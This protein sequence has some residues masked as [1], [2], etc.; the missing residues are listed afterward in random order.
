VVRLRWRATVR[1]RVDRGDVCMSAPGFRPLVCTGEGSRTWLI[2][3]DADRIAVWDGGMRDNH[4]TCGIYGDLRAAV[5]ALDD[6][7]EANAASI[8]TPCATGEEC[9]DAE[10]EG[11]PPLAMSC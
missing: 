10:P 2:W 3:S 11:T 7:M 8:N 1:R 4:A 9:A 5:N 6:F